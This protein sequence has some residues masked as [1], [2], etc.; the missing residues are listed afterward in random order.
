MG[1]EPAAG[2]GFGSEGEAARRDVAAPGSAFVRLGEVDL[3]N[4][5][6]LKEERTVTRDN[7][8]S[9]RGRSLQL[10]VAHGRHHVRRRVRVHE[11]ADATLLVHQG[12]RGWHSTNLDAPEPVALA[13]G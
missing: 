6:C 10:P 7:C 4:M 12:P 9:Y 5:L 8:V 13:A 1:E 3:D 2:C 11:H